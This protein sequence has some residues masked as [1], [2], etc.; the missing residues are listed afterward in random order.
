MPS[1]GNEPPA[2]R[3]ESSTWNPPDDVLR[4][5]AATA[6]PDGPTA[7]STV[8]PPNASDSNSAASY[9]IGAASPNA[10]LAP[11]RMTACSLRFP[12]SGAS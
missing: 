12:P 4:A 2:G 5:Q 6:V 11:G 1:A 3:R 9:E 8:P 10:P 7:T